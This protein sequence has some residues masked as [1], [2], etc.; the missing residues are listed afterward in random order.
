MENKTFSF[1]YMAPLYRLLLRK[2]YLVTMEVGS[3]KLEN[4][5]YEQTG[6]QEYTRN[7]LD[8]VPLT[9]EDSLK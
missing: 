2:Q 3:G 4:S 6:V 1:I 7:E 9:C 5:I 8:V